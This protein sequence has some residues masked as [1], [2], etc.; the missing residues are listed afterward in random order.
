LDYLTGKQVP[1]TEFISGARGA[2]AD[3]AH[4]NVIKDCKTVV[5]KSASVLL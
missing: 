4:F 1:V 5:L 3:E 2:Q